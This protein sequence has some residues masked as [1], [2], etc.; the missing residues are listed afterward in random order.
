MATL[1]VAV[2]KS[3]QQWGGDVGLGKHL[4]KVGLAA[5]TSPEESIAGAA[6]CDDWKILLAIPTD[7]DE[8]AILERL[9]IKE[10]LVD[11]TYYPRLKGMLGVV[12]VSIASVENAMLVTIALDNRNA[13]KDFKVKPADIAQHLIRNL[14]KV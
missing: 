1:Y 10:K 3:L 12:K 4:Y 8:A 2:S 7:K 5:E 9:A 11:P 6:G 13:P 14:I